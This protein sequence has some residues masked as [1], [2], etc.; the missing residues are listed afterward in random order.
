VTVADD[1]IGAADESAGTGLQ[2]LHERVG[3][4][5]GQLTISS[6]AGVGTTVAA[7]FPVAEVRA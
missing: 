4:V 3:A 2:G 1:G 5:G 6:P 7:S